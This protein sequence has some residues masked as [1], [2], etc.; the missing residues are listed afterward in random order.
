MAVKVQKQPA[1]KS[2]GRKCEWC[3]SA[4]QVQPVYQRRTARVRKP[5]GCSTN[6]YLTRRATAHTMLERYFSIQP[7]GSVF[8][9]DRV[10][11]S[12]YAML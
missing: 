9:N 4:L 7:H 8:C 12:L 6:L 10:L 5:G 3:C 1:M 11:P 2:V